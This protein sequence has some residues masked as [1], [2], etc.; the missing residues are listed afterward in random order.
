MAE[1]VT[2]YEEAEVATSLQFGEEKA[3]GMCSRF[4]KS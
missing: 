2:F 4:T 3:M 1:V